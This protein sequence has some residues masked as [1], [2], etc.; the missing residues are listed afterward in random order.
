MTK[1]EENPPVVVT[2]PEKTSTSLMGKVGSMI[3][4]L[5]PVSK[6]HLHLSGF[7]CYYDDTSRQLPV[8]HLC[9]HLNEDMQQCL[10]YDGNHD[11]SKLIGVEYVISERLFKTLSDEEKGYWHPHSYEVSSGLLIAPGLPYAMEDKE[12]KFLANSY[13]KTWHFWQVDQGH[14]LPIGPAKLMNS[15]FKDHQLKDS[16][17]HERDRSENV[18]TQDARQHRLGWT[19]SE[20]LPNCMRW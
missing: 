10:I 18:S 13:G 2:E 6:I 17:L 15:F 8:H 16:L 19:K 14:S 12:M 11:H 9:S 4:S 1:E 5:K 3:Q 20:I 7:H